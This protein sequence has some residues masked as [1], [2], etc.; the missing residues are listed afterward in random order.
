MCCDHKKVLSGTYFGHFLR[1]WTLSVPKQN[2][3]ATLCVTTKH[4]FTLFEH[5]FTCKSVQKSVPSLECIYNYVQKEKR[6]EQQYVQIMY[7]GG[8]Y[9]YL[10]PYTRWGSDGITRR[11][12]GS[13]RQISLNSAVWRGEFWGLFWMHA[14]IV[15][16][17]YGRE[18]CSTA[19]VPGHPALSFIIS[20]IT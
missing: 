1:F 8:Q 7:N 6:V 10:Q 11:K 2:T 14:L 12:N 15:C 4:I 5:K 9:G 13:K 3:F 17:G 16:C 20:Y 19:W 18:G